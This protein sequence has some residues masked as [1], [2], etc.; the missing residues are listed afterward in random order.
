MTM[1][2]PNAGAFT[3]LT[4]TDANE[5]AGLTARNSRSKPSCWRTKLACWNS[6]LIRMAARNE[7]KRTETGAGFRR[8]C[9]KGRGETHAA[10]PARRQKGQPRHLARH[11]AG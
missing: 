2:C 6:Q 10:E 8:G 7:R 5:W 9:R 11:Q 3:A 4:R 1:A